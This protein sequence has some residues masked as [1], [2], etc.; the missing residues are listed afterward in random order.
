MRELFVVYLKGLAMGAADTVPGVSGGTIALVVGIYDRLIRALTALDPR[1]LE[2]VTEIHEPEGRRALLASLERMDAFFLVALGLGVLTAVVALAQLAHLAFTEFPVATYAFF[3][4]LIA[5]SAVVLYGEIEDWTR[6]RVAVAV[7]GVLLAAA[8]TTVTASGVSHAYPAIFLAG[9]IAICAMVLPGVSGAFF[10]VVLGQYEYLT[11]TLDALVDGLVDVFEGGS[12][13]AVL[14]AATVVAVFCSGAVVGLFTMAHAVRFAL[15]RYRAATLAFLV[16]LMV[17]GL[18]LPIVR[19]LEHADGSSGEVV[20]AVGAASVG[21]AAVL[22][23]D[24]YTDDIA[25][26]TDDHPDEAVEPAADRRLG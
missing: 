17:G 23:V 3:C 16:S 12:L 22:L 2:G 4:G 1:E 11:G 7:V 9:A 8:I 5:A 24:R 10:L 14:E 15:D 19:L 20:A 26:E 25:Y 18:R 21:C 6:R 13:A